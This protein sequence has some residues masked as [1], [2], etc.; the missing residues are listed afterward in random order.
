[1]PR[2]GTDD[3]VVGD[4]R[5]DGGSAGE[6][7]H[8]WGGDEPLRLGERKLM[9]NLALAVAWVAGGDDGARQND[10]VHHHGIFGQVG[11]HHCHCLPRQHAAL[12][13]AAGQLA[14]TIEQLAI[15]HAA[16][17]GRFDESDLVASRRGV[18]QRE[19]RQGHSGQ[20]Q[21]LERAGKNVGRGGG[22]TGSLW[23]R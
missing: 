16:A 4:G 15:G 1:M 19:L 13:E 8:A 9:M 18:P 23:L 3:R 14:H 2:A 10:A 21:W 6:G 12:F 17:A 5:A 7:Q 11:Q 22:H 20:G